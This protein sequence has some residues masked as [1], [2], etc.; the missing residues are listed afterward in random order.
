[1]RELAVGVAEEGRADQVAYPAEVDRLESKFQKIQRRGHQG[2]TR[3]R[4]SEGNVERHRRLRRAGKV[5]TGLH[6][7]R[8]NP[9]GL[10]SM[11]GQFRNDDADARLAFLQA[12]ARPL[13][14]GFDLV[15]RRGERGARKRSGMALR[16]A[17]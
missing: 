11:L 4:L 14:R 2:E 10:R 9:D 8:E 16:R 5:V 3:Q 1:V 7:A 15:L 6:D 13:R 12:S 17:I